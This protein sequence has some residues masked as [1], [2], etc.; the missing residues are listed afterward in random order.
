MGF[1]D[2]DDVAVEEEEKIVN[3][4]EE[5][6]SNH[7]VYSREKFLNALVYRIKDEYK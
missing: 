3:T 2:E 7:L 5:K 1:V 4:K 6:V